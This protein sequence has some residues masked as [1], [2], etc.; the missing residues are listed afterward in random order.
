MEIEIINTRTNLSLSLSSYIYPSG[1]LI[2]KFDP[3]R[4]SAKFNK[5]KSINQNGYTLLST[6]LEDRTVELEATILANDRTERD[7]LKRMVDEVL[8]PLDSLIIKYNNIEIKR[9]IECSAE[10]TPAYSTEF[11]DNNNLMLK[12]NISFECFKP[13]WMDQEENV[14]NV[15][16]WEGGF[17]FEFELTTGGIEF[18]RKGPNEIE[19]NNYGNIE[20]P[21][22]IYFKGPALNPSIMLDNNKYIK[23]NRTL[24][25]DEIL[26]IN[27]SYDN[28]KVQVIKNDVVQ[29]AYHYIDIE[30]TFFDLGTG[31]NKISYSTEGDYLPQQVIIKYKNHYYSI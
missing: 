29:Q 4:V 25:E 15:E 21:L 23:V 12:F 13:F 3:G 27:T 18:A 31:L 26:Y 5:I 19:I 30:S 24:L 9:E 1:L 2:N 22:E 6:I 20:A 10:E 17:E 7:T 8:N 16:T 11:K 28:K 14:L